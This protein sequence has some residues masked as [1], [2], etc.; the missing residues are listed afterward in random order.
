M[1]SLEHG[2]EH[3]S[4]LYEKLL[5]LDTLYERHLSHLTPTLRS[6]NLF[7]AFCSA[8]RAIA[9]CACIDL[10]E[11]G[12]EAWF[13]E[14]DSTGGAPFIA[15]MNAGIEQAAAMVIVAS[16][17]S[18]NSEAVKLEWA[19]G[20]TKRLTD[21][22]FLIVPVLADDCELPPLLAAFSFADLR[23]DY[24][25]GIGQVARLLSSGAR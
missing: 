18:L 8:D 2:E 1:Q 22:S 7:F 15:Q 9:K 23:K 16:R 20:I 12:H 10:C 13:Y 3:V 19:A 25:S 5:I 11:L 21:P 14:A 24:W 17:A 6:K 4:F